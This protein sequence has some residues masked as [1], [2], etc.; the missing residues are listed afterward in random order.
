[1]RDSLTRENARDFRQRYLGTYGFYTTTNKRLL[2]KMTEINERKVTFMDAQRNEFFAYADTKVEFEFIPVDRGFYNSQEDA[3]L[4][5]RVPSRQWSRGISD[6]N[7]TVQKMGKGGLIPIQLS[8]DLL[9]GIFVGSPDMEMC[10]KQY[11]EGKRQTVALSKYF[12]LSPD[13]LYFYEARV[14]TREGDT[15]TLQN[16]QVYQEVSDLIRRNSLP[17]TLI[18]Q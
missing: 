3:V 15:L 9:N 17:F 18:A 4:L 10:L 2:V 11:L 1:M 14:G 5:T 8:M 6:N 7:T 16:D 13:G 12:A